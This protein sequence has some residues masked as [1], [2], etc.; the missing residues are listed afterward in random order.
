[1]PDLVFKFKDFYYSEV[2][3]IIHKKI[4]F[5]FIWLL[6]EYIFYYCS[7]NIFKI[8]FEEVNLLYVLIIVFTTFLLLLFYWFFSINKIQKFN[9]DEIGII[10]AFTKLD[11][12]T[13][14]E[15]N[16]IHERIKQ[17]IDENNFKTKISIRIVPDWLTP[18]N[19]YSAH[20][21]RKKFRS[22]LIIWG[23]VDMGNISSDKCTVFV[24]IYFSYDICLPP[25]KAAIIN[26]GFNSVLANRKWIISEKNNI[27][28]REFLLSN[29][30]EISLYFVGTVLLF[31]NMND[32]A[33]EIL[34]LVLKKYSQ[35]NPQSTDD[36]IAIRNLI[37]FLDRIFYDRIKIIDLYPNCR[38]KDENIKRSVSVINDFKDIIGFNLSV[39]LIESQVK[40]AEGNIPKAKSLLKDVYQKDLNN[41]APCFSLAFLYFYEG[42]LN[43]GWH[44]L[45]LALSKRRTF[46]LGI[47]SVRIVRWYEESLR[48]DSSKDF[49]NFPMAMIYYEIIGD[50]KSAEES[51]EI[52]LKKYKNSS[53]KIHQN[54]VWLSQKYL[55]KI[56]KR[57][58]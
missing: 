49:L 55:K 6:S 37:I 22:K 11:K 14:E 45:K 21:I 3:P 24:P 44:W 12:K 19:E 8:S 32:E 20:K 7:T 30:E 18:K 27:F 16:K 28:D 38:R 57:V 31:S 1:M 2:Q 25:D 15:L 58:D 35:K 40:F 52:T 17:L 9:S 41:S 56:K 47:D 36:A 43:K 46:R 5:V 51:F 34:G 50:Y 13:D 26:S 48:E 54:I 33:F 29:L 4:G 23:N 39:L 42:D 10:I 53:E